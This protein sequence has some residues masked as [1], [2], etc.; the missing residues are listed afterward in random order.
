MSGHEQELSSP[1]KCLKLPKRKGYRSLISLIGGEVGQHPADH[2]S[3]S[4]TFLVFTFF[5]SQCDMYKRF[6]HLSAIA[7]KIHVTTITS[8]Y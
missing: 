6:K 7:Y 3:F 2:I 4:S 8:S 5:F 1:Y